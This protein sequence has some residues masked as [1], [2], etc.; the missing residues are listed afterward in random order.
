MKSHNLLWKTTTVLTLTVFVSSTLYAAVTGPGL[1]T[2]SDGDPLTSSAWNSM[3]NDLNAYNAPNKIVRQHSDGRVGIGTSSPGAMLHVVNPGA[4]GLVVSGSSNAMFRLHGTGHDFFDIETT[5]QGASLQINDTNVLRLADSGYASF[6]SRVGIGTTSPTSHLHVKHTNSVQ[7][8]IDAPDDKTPALYLNH[9]GVPR[10]AIDL[11]ATTHDLRFWRY[12]GSAWQERMRIDYDTGNVGIGTTNPDA[13]LDVYQDTVGATGYQNGIRLLSVSGIDSRW[14]EGGGSDMGIGTQGNHSFALRTNNSAR[15]FV[16]GAGDVGIGTTSPTG[17]FEV[18]GG[19]SFLGGIRINGQDG[20]VNQIWQ[21]VSGKVLGITGRDSGLSLG[22]AVSQQHLFIDA[23]GDVGIG[24]TTPDGTLKLDVEGAIG[25]SQLCD[26]NGAN[27]SSIATLTS[28]VSPW[29]K[30]GSHINYTTGSVSMGTTTPFGTLHLR[31]TGTN[32]DI[33][34]ASPSITF[35]HQNGTYTA[36]DYYGV[37]RWARPNS[38][39]GTPVAGIAAKT[40]AT[41]SEA[42]LVFFT[43]DGANND[44]LERMVIKNNGWFGFGTSN[45]TLPFTFS[46]PGSFSVIA[47][48]SQRD[49]PVGGLFRFRHSRAPGDGDH[50]IVQDGDA[51]GLIDAYGSDGTD[52]KRAAFLEI[53]V[54]GTPGIDDMPGRITFGTTPDG[55]LTPLER[56]RIDNAGNVG[57]GTTNPAA[58]FVVSDQG[59]NASIFIEGYKNAANGSILRFRHSRAEVDGGHTVLQ[60]GDV[61][62][63][64]QFMGSD[65]TSWKHGA[66]IEA[67]VDGTP[68]TNDMPGRLVFSTSADGTSSVV[69][70]MRIDANGNVGIGT[71]NPAAKLTIEPGGAGATIIGGRNIHLGVHTKTTSGR[72]GYSVE[73]GNNWTGVEDNA[74]FYWM[75]PFD[76]NGGPGTT[77]YKPFRLATGATLDDKFYVLQN[78]GGYFAGNVGIGTTNPSGNLHVAS[79]SWAR[80]YLESTGAA[81]DP[82]LFLKSLSQTFKWHVDE[83]DGA[84]L[85]LSNVTAST[86]P[87]VVTP[88]DNIGIG[89]TTPSAKLHVKDGQM[90]SEQAST[91]TPGGTT[92]TVDW[93]TSNAQEIDLGS[94]TGDVT[95]TLN[96]PVAGAA[97]FVKVVQGATARQLVWPANVKWPGGT[98]HTLT[99]TDDAIDSITL[100]YDG[101][102]YLANGSAD[103]Q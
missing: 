9:A 51:L 101:T 91:L 58:D 36:G 61:L 3:V 103:Y 55:A 4:L 98:A 30:N 2:V 59:T 76:T 13:A 41:A 77:G 1:A 79:S 92:Q 69:E 6:D 31:N 46:N 21:S 45:P 37:M 25:A 14:F 75:Y 87:L 81:Q 20:S 84:M 82:E 35:S 102:N 83:S 18:V 80:F 85:K 60:N 8:A 70:R 50:V 23:T 17:K 67:E 10:G 7:V 33:D 54:D 95:L 49:A 71:T 86:A 48:E 66:K 65:G 72:S 19:E 78:G 47:L 97:Y 43:Q 63:E 38:N 39:G 89:T 24:D 99:T 44:R 32:A 42:D 12:T 40:G 73:V 57:I 52:W 93:N 22:G 34:V 100:Y 94:A 26:Q 64:L 56:M 53:E 68:G 29:T 62:G 88:T 11:Q 27:C 28:G 16:S 90:V 15:L 5:A 74:G 96:N